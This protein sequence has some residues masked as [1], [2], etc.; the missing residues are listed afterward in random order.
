LA[1]YF[2]RVFML[3]FLRAVKDQTPLCG[4]AVAG[5]AWETGVV[6]V[7]ITHRDI[8]ADKLRKRKVIVRNYARGVM[9]W[10]GNVKFRHL[11]FLGL[12]RK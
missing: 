5:A 6:N 11:D 9:H 1:H 7:E 10:S 2:W 12:D 4:V 8:F 3:R